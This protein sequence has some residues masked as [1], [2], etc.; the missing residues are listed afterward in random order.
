MDLHKACQPQAERKKGGDESDRSS[1][2]NRA[3]IVA[4]DLGIV[5]AVGTTAFD[6]LGIVLAVL[7]L[8]VL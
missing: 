5:A 4:S 1:N 2:S 3:R 8:F 7:A 6:A